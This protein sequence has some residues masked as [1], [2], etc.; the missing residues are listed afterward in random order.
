MDPN[1]IIGA[2]VMVTIF[3]GPAWLTF[4]YLDRANEAKRMSAAEQATLAQVAAL[5]SRIETRMDAVERVLDADAPEWRGRPPAR[6]Q[7]G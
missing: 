4:R 2:I 6:R 5:A 7:A 1:M 3:L